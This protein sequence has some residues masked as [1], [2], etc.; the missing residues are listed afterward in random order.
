M[1][2]N[3]MTVFLIDDDDVACESVIRSFKKHDIPFN[4]VTAND[5]VEGLEILR[6]QHP[7]K[8][9]HDPFLILLDLNMPRMNGFEFL[10][11]LRDDPN[12]NNCVVFVLTTSNNDSDRAKAYNK[13]IA[14]Y[15]VKSEVGPQFAKLSNLLTQYKAAVTLPRAS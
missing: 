11:E 6:N 3:E 4:I 10:D 15:M 12:L 1:L 14:G 9:I 5:G 2:T 8:N 13:Q 7:K